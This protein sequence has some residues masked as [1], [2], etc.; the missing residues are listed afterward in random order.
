MD[1]Y[2]RFEETLSRLFGDAMKI[3][4]EICMDIWSALANVDW[5]CRKT[6]ETVGY[7]FRAAGSLIANIRGSGSYLDWYC[8]SPSGSVSDY[9]AER[10][11]EEDWVY[12]DLEWR[13]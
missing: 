3:D 13:Y 10:M 8:A 2:I 1:S 12:E 6:G 11:F 5:T 9:I 4:D 7:S